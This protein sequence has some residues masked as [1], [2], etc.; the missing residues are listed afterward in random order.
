VKETDSSGFLA[1]AAAKGEQ[2]FVVVRDSRGRL[3]D[4]LLATG[5]FKVLFRQGAKADRSL[6]LLTNKT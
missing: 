4:E 5:R 6:V 3:E 2:I 1:D